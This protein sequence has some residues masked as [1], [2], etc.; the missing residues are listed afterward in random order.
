MSAPHRALYPRRSPATLLALACA[1]GG[2]MTSPH[3][4]QR[5]ATRAS[6]VP[7]AGYHPSPGLALSVEVAA[8]GG[9]ERIATATTSVDPIAG[10]EPTL[11]GWSTEDLVLPEA[12]WVPG[13]RG[14]E[15]R[16]RVRAEGGASQLASV[17]SDWAACWARVGHDLRRFT[18]ECSAPESPIAR[19]RTADYVPFYSGFGDTSCA[20]GEADCNRCAEDVEGTFAGL[21]ARAVNGAIE[22][23]PSGKVRY[24]ANAGRRL[25]PD[26]VA[27][28]RLDSFRFH[29]EGFARVPG[30]G[31]ENWFI[32]TLLTQRQSSGF[33]LAQM[34]DLPGHGGERIVAPGQDPEVYFPIRPRPA[35]FGENALPEP[36]RGFHYFHRIP[37]THHTG[38]IQVI[39]RTAFIP[40]QVSG[41]D[42]VDIY[43]LSAPTR[44]ARI[45]TI[46]LSSRSAGR[47]VDA[48]NQVSVARMAS[49]HY[50]L[51]VN[52]SNGGVTDVYVSDATQLDEGVVW[53]RV[54]STVFRDL[55]PRWSTSK[56][57]YQNVNFVTDCASGRLYLVALMQDD[58]FGSPWNA[59]NV[60]DLYRAPAR[61]GR[62][63][64][65]HVARQTFGRAGNSCE[66]RGGASVHVTPSGEMIVY[67]T[68]GWENGRGIMRFAELT[69]PS[70]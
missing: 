2:C 9:F 30:L 66:M 37:G 70:R 51:L 58:A 61:G 43:D 26:A 13:F 27:V 46:T 25:P 32:A 47:W 16:V 20:Y 1:L 6:P 14:H 15:A 40:Y 68:S 28:E 44:T 54:E 41:L 63:A 31:P 3:D 45:G 35:F 48:A 52:R 17:R 69:A 24:Y 60:V 4:D 38:G 50:V 23:G 7:V 67:C 62:L 22:R 8:N 21:G 10:G 29:I 39:G 55:S 11:Y 49:G 65:E 12:A 64:L 53:L 42:R 56:N 34:R 57:T 59:H 36:Y 19:V 33:L 5:V 18:G